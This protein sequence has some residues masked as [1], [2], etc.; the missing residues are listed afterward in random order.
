MNRCIG[1]VG[2]LLLIIGVQGA[3]A[4]IELPEPVF[5]GISVFSAELST[6]SSPE[7]SDPELFFLPAP[8]LMFSEF[9][10]LV[11]LWSQDAGDGAERLE[12]SPI[13]T[14][15][16][17]ASSDVSTPVVPLNVRNNQYY[18]ESVRLTKLAQE[19]FDYGDYDASS[20]YAEEAQHYADLS[21][22]YVALQLKIKETNDAIAAARKRL[23]WAVSIK[24]ADRYPDEMK[25]AQAAYDEALSERTAKQWDPAIEAAGRVINALAYVREA[26]APPPPPRAEDKPALPAQY[27][28]RPWAVSKDCFWNIAGRAWVYGDS[29]KWR[30]IYNAN[31][32]KLPNPDNPDLM[33]PGTILDIPSVQGE[34]RQGM[35][36]SAKTYN[37]LR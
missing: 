9:Q 21:D 14:L 20:Q 18:L 35:W 23:D 10:E 22:E 29:T 5:H 7:L 25:T 4:Q 26:D 28:V 2:A 32:A 13:L 17:A 8:G 19:S 1:L 11:Y 24:A 6:E 15:A 31:R 33:H 12:F 30:I 3:F 16:A 36:D 34:T 37:P 27:T